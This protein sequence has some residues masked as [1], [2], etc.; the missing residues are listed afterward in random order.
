MK[1]GFSKIFKLLPEKLA[2]YQTQGQSEPGDQL[3]APGPSALWKLSCGGA[4]AFTYHALCSHTHEVARLARLLLT[5]LCH[6]DRQ[7]SPKRPSEIPLGFHS[8]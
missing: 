2:E 5:G 4:C 8:T 6:G 7:P 3:S 1:L